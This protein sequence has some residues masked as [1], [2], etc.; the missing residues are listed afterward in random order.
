[1]RIALSLA[2][3]VLLSLI[4]SQP[5]SAAGCTPQEGECLEYLD[6]ASYIDGDTGGSCTTV[7]RT[8]VRPTGIIVDIT[9][10]CHLQ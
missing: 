6:T 7:I 2:L 4:T 3:V 9:T 8:I 1:M 5:L 10:I